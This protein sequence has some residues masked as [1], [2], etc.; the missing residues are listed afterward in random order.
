MVKDNCF[1]FLLLGVDYNGKE[2]QTAFEWSK[3]E[4]F[5]KPQ[6]DMSEESDHQLSFFDE[7]EKLIVQRNYDHKKM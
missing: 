7:I 1:I 5:E 6:N 3:H 4:S 2:L